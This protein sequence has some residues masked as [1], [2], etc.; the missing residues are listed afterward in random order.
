MYLKVSHPSRVLGG[1]FMNT[2]ATSNNFIESI[3]DKVSNLIVI[4]LW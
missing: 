4:L 2:T 1:Y 3:Q